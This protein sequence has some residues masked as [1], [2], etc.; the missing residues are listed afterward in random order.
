MYP[1]THELHSDRTGM[2]CVSHSHG[3]SSLNSMLKHCL[4]CAVMLTLVLAFTH[5]SIRRQL[6]FFTTEM[7]WNA[8]MDPFHVYGFYLTILLYL[9]RFCV[10]L[11]L[12]NFL[13]NFCGL[14]YYKAFN[15]RVILKY[16]PS[17]APFICFRI[18]TKG[19]YP[20]LVCVNALRNLEICL[21]V[22]LEKFLIEVVTEKSVDDLLNHPKVRQVVVPTEYQCERG[23]QFKVS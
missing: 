13:F 2:E 9:P 10:L 16:P 20:D 14:L 23:T 8:N 21:Q 1:H 22:K 5:K 7:E 11:T 3:R 15:E 12:P 19:L 17:R 6:V 4:H 18:V